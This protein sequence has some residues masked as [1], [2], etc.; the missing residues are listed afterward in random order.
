[1][2]EIEDDS[3]AIKSQRLSRMLTS[4]IVIVIIVILLGTYVYLV[5]SC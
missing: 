3:A 2:K 4:I 5:V 1:M